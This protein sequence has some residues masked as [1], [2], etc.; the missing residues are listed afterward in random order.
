MHVHTNWNEAIS[1]AKLT[2]H[3]VF[4]MTECQ[5]WS[6]W[7]ANLSK[8][9]Q[10]SQD[11]EI[12]Q[13]ESKISLYWEDSPVWVCDWNK[14][15]A[16]LVGQWCSDRKK[17]AIHTAIPPRMWSLGSR[18]GQHPGLSSIHYIRYNGQPRVHLA[19]PK[20][21]PSHP[22]KPVLAYTELAKIAYYWE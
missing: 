14:M 7:E 9:L 19:H 11:R 15:Q 5:T 3:I 2:G 12:Q 20:V 18:L 8:T 1:R 13:S 17:Y 10:N 6:V 21:T 4:P 16:V 22:S